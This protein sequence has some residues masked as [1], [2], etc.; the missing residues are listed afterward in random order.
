MTTQLHNTCIAHCI[1]SHVTE[2]VYMVISSRIVEDLTQLFA[3]HDTAL[4]LEDLPYPDSEPAHFERYEQAW[5]QLVRLVGMEYREA[6]E[7]TPVLEKAVALLQGG[8]TA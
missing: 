6:M 4:R 1:R 2:R 7:M 3:E 8:H 5:R